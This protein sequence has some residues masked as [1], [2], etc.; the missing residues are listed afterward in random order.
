M[1][2]KYQDSLFLHHFTATIEQWNSRLLLVDEPELQ[3]SANFPSWLNLLANLCLPDCIWCKNGVQKAELLTFS[4]FF[5]KNE[6]SSRYV[7]RSILLQ[8]NQYLAYLNEILGQ[9]NPIS[10]DTLLEIVGKMAK[11]CSEFHLKCV[12]MKITLFC[13]TL[14]QVLTTFLVFCR[15]GEGRGVEPGFI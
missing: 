5:V 7:I 2:D 13:A 11:T 10:P 1:M 6:M 12:H 15:R 14:P 9:Q 3:L 8:F 4:F